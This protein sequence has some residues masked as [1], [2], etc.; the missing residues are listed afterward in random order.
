MTAEMTVAEYIA[1]RLDVSAK[2]QRQIAAEA[3]FPHPNFLS[4]IRHGTSKVPVAA[5][6]RLAKA[7]GISP[8]QLTRIVIREY[9]PELWEVLESTFALSVTENEAEFI[10][11]V[12]NA[13]SNTD[14]IFDAGFLDK[15][16]QLLAEEGMV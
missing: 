6:P 8:K 11:H 15:F 13:T 14:P 5:A 10:R 12:R 1:H 2:T 9:H 4:M 3:G 7:L 16:D